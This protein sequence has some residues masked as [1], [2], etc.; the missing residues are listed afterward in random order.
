M[1]QRGWAWDCAGVSLSSATTSPARAFS[2]SGNS[3]GA[4]LCQT[5]RLEHGC[6][7]QLPGDALGHCP[8]KFA[9]LTS[10]PAPLPSPALPGLRASWK[11]A[12]PNRVLQV[13]QVLQ[14]GLLGQNRGIAPSPL[15]C[16][17]WGQSRVLCQWV[18]SPRGKLG[19]FLELKAPDAMVL[20]SPSLK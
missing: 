6:H 20:A 11:A 18:A 7:Q 19:Q 2:S 4:N 8:G 14:G 10:S 16:P 17:S 1:H 3:Q 13:L 9:P 12:V 15:P 5:A